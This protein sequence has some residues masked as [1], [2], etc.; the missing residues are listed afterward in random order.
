MYLSVNNYL[1]VELFIITEV[2]IWM[3]GVSKKILFYIIMSTEY[4]IYLT[5]EPSW[6]LWSPIP[7]IDY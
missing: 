4:V 1:K 3:V 2:Q 5:L 7:K 6:L